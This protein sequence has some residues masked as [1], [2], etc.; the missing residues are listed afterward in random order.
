MNKNNKNAT[1]EILADI[2]QT[3]NP[4]LKKH[5][6]ERCII[7]PMAFRSFSTG[8]EIFLA[9]VYNKEPETV[10]ISAEF[11]E[12][13]DK[14]KFTDCLYL[15]NELNRLVPYGTFK[16][17]YE[18]DSI[19]VGRDLICFGD[20]RVTHDDVFG[21]IT[22]IIAPFDILQETAQS[23]IDGKILRELLPLALVKAQDAFFENKEE[24]EEDEEE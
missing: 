16:Y 7:Y 10:S 4:E 15:V 17:N 9:L 20:H 18:E 22:S 3:F 12:V 13:P 2:A 19:F 5:E 8:S 1:L 24:D 11:L 21:A 6:D 23:F 14:K